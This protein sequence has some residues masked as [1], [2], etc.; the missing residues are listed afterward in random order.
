[1]AQRLVEDIASAYESEESPSGEASPA[2]ASSPPMASPRPHEKTRAAVERTLKE[3]C[4]TQPGLSLRWFLKGLRPRLDGL[5]TFGRLRARRKAR[6]RAARALRQQAEDTYTPMKEWQRL[7][8]VEWRSPTEPVFA[9]L[10][11]AVLSSPVPR[12]YYF[13]AI[14]LAAIGLG[15]IALGGW[16]QQEAVMVAGGILAIWTSLLTVLPVRW[17][18]C[19]RTP[20]P[21][22]AQDLAAAPNL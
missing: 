4:S 17:V 12:G 20:I 10:P 5:T 8:G 1:M 3:V 18:E 7:P 22:D 14:G 2:E 11:T 15:M 21:H 6:F 13:W 9:Q 16:R 19:R